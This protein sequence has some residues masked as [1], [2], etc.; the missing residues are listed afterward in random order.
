MDEMTE[1][2]LRLHLRKVCR[3]RATLAV[4]DRP[5]IDAWTVD[6]S[7]DGMSLMLAE[8]IDSGQYCVIKFEV[9]IDEEVKLF[10]AIAKSIYSVCS[11]TGQFRTGLQF[12]ELNAA[13]A[14]I[15]NALKD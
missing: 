1:V 9:T 3:S 11:S 8:P 4:L 5:P 13:N 14:A 15:I 7:V 10:S 12:H 6:I 2:D